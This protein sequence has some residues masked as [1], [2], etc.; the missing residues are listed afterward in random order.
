MEEEVLINEQEFEEINEEY[1]DTI[2]YTVYLF[3][4]MIGPFGIT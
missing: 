4:C 3:K 1:E 2:E